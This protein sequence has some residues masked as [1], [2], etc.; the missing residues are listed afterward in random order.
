VQWCHRTR[1]TSAAAAAAAN[2][3]HSACLHLHFR[4]T[5]HTHTHTTSLRSCSGRP[6]DKNEKR[7]VITIPSLVQ[8]MRGSGGSLVTSHEK[9]AAL[10]STTRWSFGR[11]TNWGAPTSTTMFTISFQCSKAYSLADENHFS[12]VN[13]VK[14]NSTKSRFKILFRFFFLQWFIIWLAKTQSS[15]IFCSDEYKVYYRLGL[16]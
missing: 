1:R 10:P 5:T 16:Q 9:N 12:L 4:V 13:G 15:V 11:F 3:V 6:T 7:T 14:W 8:W 2:G